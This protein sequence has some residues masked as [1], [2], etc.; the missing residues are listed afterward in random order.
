[1]IQKVTEAIEKK[2]MFIARVIDPCGNYGGQVVL[3]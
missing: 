2:G 1:M 3:L